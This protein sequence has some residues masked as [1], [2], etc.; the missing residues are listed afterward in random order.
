LGSTTGVDSVIVTWPG[1]TVQDSLGIA[2]DQ[3]IIIVE[4]T[5]ADVED[6]EILA[7]TFRLDASYPN[8]F[9]S[10]TTIRY[11]LPEP[12]IVGLR[13]YDVSGRLVRILADKT[14]ASA[15]LHRVMWDGKDRSGHA[16]APGVYFYRI[17]WNGRHETKRMVLLR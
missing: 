10:G 3:R 9:H 16:A 5:L 11:E 6:V 2:A 17:A 4:P 15:G 12:G 1:G 7:G 13:I 8:P 14:E